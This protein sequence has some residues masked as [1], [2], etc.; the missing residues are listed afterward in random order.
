MLGFT[1]K[2]LS[3]TEDLGKICAHPTCLHLMPSWEQ[4]LVGGMMMRIYHEC[5][6]RIEKSFGGSQFGITRLAE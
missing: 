6:G 4:H 2:N 1:S 5:E 3:K